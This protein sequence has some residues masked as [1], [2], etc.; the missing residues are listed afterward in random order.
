MAA[1][2]LLPNST[3]AATSADFVVTVGGY[4][5]LSSALPLHQLSNASIQIKNA[6]ATYTPVLNISGTKPL[7][8]LL[9]VATYRVV[10]DAAPV[11]YG[12]NTQLA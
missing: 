8:V 4:V 12:V 9:P 11:A 1:V 3:D 2:E 7:S 6:D 10:K 5:N